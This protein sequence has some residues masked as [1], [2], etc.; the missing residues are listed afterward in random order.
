M[1]DT[2][3][4]KFQGKN[5]R[6]KICNTSEECLCG[7]FGIQIIAKAIESESNN[8]SKDTSKLSKQGTKKTKWTCYPR[9][10]GQKENVYIRLKMKAER[11]KKERDEAIFQTLFTNN[12]LKLISEVNT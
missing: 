5:A 4:R 6:D 9:T 12:L 1:G 8:M 11:D 2:E 3:G 7:L 10:V